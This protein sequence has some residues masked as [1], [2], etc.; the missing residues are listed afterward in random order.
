MTFVFLSQCDTFTYFYT[1]LYR[2]ICV[3]D[4]LVVFFSQVAVGLQYGD[5]FYSMISRSPEEGDP[6]Q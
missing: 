5:T 3:S 2:S 6:Q 1:F 4:K